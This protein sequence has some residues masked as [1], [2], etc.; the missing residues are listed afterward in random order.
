MVPASITMS[1]TG[2]CA[3]VANIEIAA[4]SVPSIVNPAIV[5]LVAPDEQ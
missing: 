2:F 3:V 1:F 5:P 4:P